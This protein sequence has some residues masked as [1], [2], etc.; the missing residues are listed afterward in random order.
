M[1][2][3]MVYEFQKIECDFLPH[4]NTGVPKSGPSWDY[5]ERILLNPKVDGSL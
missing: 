2:K 1:A 3:W 4:I 5:R